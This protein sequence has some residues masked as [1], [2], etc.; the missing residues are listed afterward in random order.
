MY[1][2]LANGNAE[3]TAKYIKQ[4]TYKLHHTFK[5]SVITLKQ[6]PFLIARVGWGYFTIF[7]EI[8]F[9]EHLK[10]PKLLQEH[11]LNFDAPNTSR[12]FFI[13]YNPTLQ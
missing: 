4:V 7:V 13:D 1:V 10:I 8:E 2:V 6:P 11:E 12:T 3:E 9:H 5:P